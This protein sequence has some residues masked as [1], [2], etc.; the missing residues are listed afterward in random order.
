M[1][2]YNEPVEWL[3]QSIESILRQTYSDI[4]FII[5]LDNPYN[6]V[7]GDLIENYAVKDQRIR[8]IRN[9]VNLGLAATLDMGVR[10]ARGEYIARMDADDI[11]RKVRFEKQLAYLE[12]HSLDV[13]GSNIQYIDENGNELQKSKKVTTNIYIKRLLFT[14][15]N[16]LTHPTFFGRTEVFRE[17]GYRQ[18]SLVEDKDFIHR[19]IIAGYRLGNVEDILLMYRMRSNSLSQSNLF[20]Q[21]RNGRL[22]SRYFRRNR[23]WRKMYPDFSSFDFEN[24]NM[25]SELKQRKY[26]LATKIFRRGYQSIKNRRLMGFYYCL[27]AILIS[28][29]VLLK[30]WKH[31]CHRLLYVCERYPKTTLFNKQIKQ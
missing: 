1:A 10:L 14:G 2:A 29:I 22:L 3:R 13:I 17:I 23:L 9:E 21:M 15:S 24:H 16:A 7:L 11:S 20:K 6:K 28:P 19:T 5:F 8:F 31:I 27:K 18:I 12:L 30:L 4:E 25:E 26:L